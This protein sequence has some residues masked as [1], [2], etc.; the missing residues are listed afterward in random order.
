MNGLRLRRCIVSVAVLVAASL[1]STTDLAAA[2]S[3]ARPCGK[4]TNP[5]VQGKRIPKPPLEFWGTHRD[6]EVVVRVAVKADGAA[7]LQEVVSTPGRNYTAAAL[8][9]LEDWM[10]VA[11]TCDGA[12][13][14]MSMTTSIKFEH[15]REHM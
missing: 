11:G 9:A 6:Q 4:T 10:F 7:V 5:E 12:P 15:G 2:G 1:A 14:E 13:V 3:G 8:D